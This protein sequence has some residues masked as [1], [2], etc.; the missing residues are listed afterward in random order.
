MQTN[1][2]GRNG[3]FHTLSVLTLGWAFL[4]LGATAFGGLGAALA[5]I[6]RELVDRRGVLTRDDLT[7]ALTYT[8][9]LPGSTVL[10]VVAYLGFKLGGWGG[11][12][13]ATAALI[14]PSFLAMLLLAA[15]YVA[16]T[17]LPGMGPAVGGLTAAVV[18][19]LL[20]TTYRLG[21]SNVKEPLTLG[22]ALVAFAAGT[23]LDLNAAL[24][25]V[26]AGLI[27]V[28][29]LSKPVAN[30]ERTRGGAR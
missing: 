15:L 19:V 7:E 11:S 28:P 17:A 30:K 22:I 1:N 6:E 25:V 26:A 16:A 8:K 5:L 23:L 18:G 9:L 21:R 29:L 20:A 27:G 2:H 4:R 14:F 24:I 12:A 13:L 10:Q 3:T